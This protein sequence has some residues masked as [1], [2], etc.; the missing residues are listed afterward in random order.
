MTR[1]EVRKAADNDFEIEAVDLR[2]ESDFYKVY[3]EQA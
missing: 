3:I 1:E 2:D